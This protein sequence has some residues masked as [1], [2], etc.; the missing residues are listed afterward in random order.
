MQSSRQQKYGTFHNFLDGRWF[1]VLEMSWTGVLI[2][3][4]IIVANTDFSQMHNAFTNLPSFPRRKGKS[5]TIKDIAAELGLSF[6]AVSQAL[7]PRKNTSHVSEATRKRV[8][9]TARRM[10]YRGHQAARML[11]S[12][13][14]GLLGVLIFDHPHQVMHYRLHHILAEIHA[15]GYRPFVHLADT[16]QNSGAMDGCLAMLDANVEGVLFVDPI[17]FPEESPVEK[18]LECQIP[19]ISIGSHQWSGITS[20]QADRKHGFYALTRH[21]LQAGCRSLVL[22]KADTNKRYRRFFRRF[23]N[24][25]TAGFHQAVREADGEFGLIEA[26]VQ[27]VEF[28]MDR[29]E[30]EGLPI[31]PIHRSGYVGMLELLAKDNL[32]DALLCQADCWALGAL[33]ACYESGIQ[34][35]TNL[36]LTGFNDEPG[37]SVGPPPLTTI[38][39]PHAEIARRAIADVV[40]QIQGGKIP[41]PGEVVTVPGFLIERASSK[42]I[43]KPSKRMTKRPRKTP[44]L[45]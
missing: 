36:L 22:L 9:E 11:R 15:A 32:P 16:R 3:L 33:R 23:M 29:E 12:G 30:T 31:H 24:D 6:Q 10:G 26:R 21:L 28:G 2:H 35:P 41:P 37:G 39:Q 19:V 7:N 13:R 43:T 25:M 45:P 18:L 20:Y 44:S 38:A 4:S 8:E 42:R 14:S 27:T 34:I 17:G 1:S 5:V 40:S